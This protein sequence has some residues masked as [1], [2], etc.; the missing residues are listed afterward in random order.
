MCSVCFESVP[1]RNHFLKV[2]DASCAEQIFLGRRPEPGP[3]SVPHFR[4]NEI[5]LTRA[6]SSLCASGHR[7]GTTPMSH[8]RCSTHKFKVLQRLWGHDFPRIIKVK[9]LFSREQ[10]VLHTVHRII[11]SSADCCKTQ[12]SKCHKYPLYFYPGK[13]QICEKCT[14]YLYLWATWSFSL[15]LFPVLLLSKRDKKK[16]EAK[17]L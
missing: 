5:F 4:L 2:T 1:D 14:K 8:T 15:S 10:E 11:V 7:L 12:W 3:G 13:V 9:L 16:F 6:L 17:K